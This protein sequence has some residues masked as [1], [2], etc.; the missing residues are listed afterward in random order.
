M[1]DAQA[2]D[3]TVIVR[4]IIDDGPRYFEAT[5]KE[6]SRSFVG[7]GDTPG[8]ALECLLDE[9]QESIAEIP[10]S[11]L[12]A[13][14]MEQE[15]EGYSGKITVRMPRSLHWKLHMLADA[16]N[17]SLNGLVNVLLA[18]GAEHKHCQLRPIGPASLFTV[19]PFINMSFSPQR[20][21]IQL[22][23]EETR[24][25][26]DLLSSVMPMRSQSCRPNT[27]PCEHGAEC[28]KSRIRNL[29]VKGG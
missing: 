9:A 23:N 12:P 13:P 8:D 26:H 10:K 15:W 18:E 29:L 25:V 20:P 14:H 24:V 19:G 2:S 1:S 27:K 16:E 11:E 4:P 28:V 6:F 21:G 5:L 7:I 22:G 17:M 3:Y